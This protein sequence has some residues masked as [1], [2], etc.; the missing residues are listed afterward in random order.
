MQGRV[1]GHRRFRGREVPTLDDHSA[2]TRLRRRLIGLQPASFDE[3]AF[4]RH[5]PLL[6]LRRE[7][8]ATHLGLQLI[9]IGQ[10]LPLRVEDIVDA[11]MMDTSRPDRDRLI[12]D[13]DRWQVEVMPAA[14]LDQ[15]TGEVLFVQPLHDR[16][17]DAALGGVEAGQQR[18]AEPGDHIR[19]LGLRG[20]ILGFHGIIDNDHVGAATCQS[21]AH[22]GCNSPAAACCKRLRVSQATP[23]RLG[24][25]FPVPNY[26][27]V[28][29]TLPRGKE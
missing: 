26:R 19:P 24:E 13:R 9:E 29:F 17:D 10:R 3:V 14:L 28:R 20:G 11:P 4:Q 23:A 2:P 5:R 25:E 12:N 21:A 18:S 7:G 6:I 8:E 22:R 16:N 15:L 27:G 1:V